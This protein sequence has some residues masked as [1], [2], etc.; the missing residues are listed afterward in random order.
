MLSIIILAAGKGTRMNSALPKV[1]QPLADKPL[2]EHVISS[3]KSL[4][5]DEIHI[6][7]GFAGEM[8]KQHFESNSKLIWAQQKEQLGTGH[9]VM[10]AAKNI[11]PENKVLILY[12][13][14]PL[15][16][17][18]TLKILIENHQ[19]NEISLL[20]AILPN[21]DGYGRIIRQE[22]N[23]QAIIEDSDASEIEKNINEINTGIMY[24]D[25]GQLN[26]WLSKLNNNNIRGEYYL[27]DIIDLAVKDGIKVNGIEAK[28]WEEVMGINDKKELAKAER[29]HQEN[30]AN[31]LMV[32]GVSL[33][34]PSRLDIRGSLTCGKD[35]VIDINVIFEGEVVIGNNVSIGP[36]NIIRNSEI[37]D[38]TVIH[39][40]CHI[41]NALIGQKSTI[42]PYAR[43]RP[44]TD[45]SEN[46]KIGNFVEVKKSIVGKNSKINHLSYIGDAKIGSSV[47]IGAGTITCNYDGANKHNT[48]IKEGAF[49]GSGVELV[50]PVVVEKNATIGAGSTISKSAPEESLTLERGRQTSH[51]KWRRPIKKI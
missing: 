42:G 51:D 45:L 9:A 36:N 4:E 29:L 22:G 37:H 48:I 43:L 41:D 5:P 46:V 3:A 15:V 32:Q 16:R 7:H 35:V 10:Q 18:E 49:I 31:D 44:G 12:G 50:A 40:N 11:S 39:A 28:K 25:A 13:D 47:N 23:V 27:T 2:L 30:L 33:L 19:N 8:I 14:V 24:C 6:V 26:G 21:A 34:D 38:N 20:T 1:L 17:L